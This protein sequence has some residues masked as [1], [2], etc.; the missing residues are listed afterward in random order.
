MEL[1][2]RMRRPAALTDWAYAT[3]KDRILSLQLPM[4]AQLKI[5]ELANQLDTS[6]TPV[7]EALL[8]LE[9]DGLVEVVPRVAFFVTEI[10]RTDVEELLEIR[11]LLETRAVKTAAL[12]LSESDLA[13]LR[14]LM[15]QGKLAA[16]EGDTEQFLQAMLDFHSLLMERAPNRRLSQ[17]M[18]RLQDL[19]YRV[20]VLALQSPHSI[21]ESLVEHGRIADALCQRDADLASRMTAEHI[22]GIRQRLLDYMELADA[23]D[24]IITD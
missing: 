21:R 1:S 13:L 10:S 7:R 20:R 23:R 14:Q 22:A 17:L 6:R 3:I 16:A 5:E 12:L 19:T 24:R 9:R 4:G 18:A 2:Q 8:R 11:E 15:D